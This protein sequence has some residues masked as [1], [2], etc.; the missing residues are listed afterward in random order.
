MGV[1]D[2]SVRSLK[3][4]LHAFLCFLCFSYTPNRDR[5]NHKTNV[6]TNSRKT[7]LHCKASKGTHILHIV[8]RFLDNNLLKTRNI[9]ASIVCAS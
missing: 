6:V 3:A 5:Y 9:L 8:W 4:R 2:A 1:P 7:R